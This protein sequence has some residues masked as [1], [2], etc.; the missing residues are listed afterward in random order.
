MPLSLQQSLSKKNHSF[1][2]WQPQLILNSLG[3][4]YWLTCLLSWSRQECDSVKE[5]STVYPTMKEHIML[6]HLAETWIW[7]KKAV[8]AFNWKLQTPRPSPPQQYA[9]RRAVLLAKKKQTQISEANVTLPGF[10][11]FSSAPSQAL[12]ELCD[13]TSDGLS[14]SLNCISFPMIQPSIQ[15][16]VTSWGL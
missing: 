12:K 10:S 5:G 14:A 8:G 13:V 1:K 2:F 11:A 9:A 16:T 15:D 7:D 6:V 4:T 3:T